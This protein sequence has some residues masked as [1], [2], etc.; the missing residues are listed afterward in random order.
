VD[1]KLGHLGFVV[2]SFVV[3]QLAGKLQLVGQELDFA[4]AA[5]LDS[6]KENR[7]LVGLE[8]VA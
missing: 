6:S 7:V 1:G 2:G 5:Y 4:S 8:A 3:D